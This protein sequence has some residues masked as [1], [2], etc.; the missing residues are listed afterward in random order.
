MKEKNDEYIL[1]NYTWTNRRH[2]NGE[3]VR[4]GSADADGASV[5]GYRPGNSYDLLGVSF[6][7][8]R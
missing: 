5:N 2:S 6:S 8:S 3:L 7:R 1:P 4:V